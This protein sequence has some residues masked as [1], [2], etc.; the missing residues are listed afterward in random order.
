MST[1]I[2]GCIEVRHPCADEDWYEWEPWQRAMDLSPLYSGQDYAAFGCLFGVRDYMGWEPLAADRGLP[3]D[4]STAIREEFEQAQALDA[5]V[6]SPTWVSWEEL[7]QAELDLSPEGVH[8]VLIVREGGTPYIEARYVVRDQWPAE[9]VE[10]HGTPPMGADPL[11]APYGEWASGT[12]K[13]SYQR[14]TR[15]DVLGPGTGWEHVFAVMRALAD[16]FGGDGVR[17]VVYFD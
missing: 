11:G 10:R 4:A 17:L 8:G 3:A 13:F 16:R 9:F 15:R 14:F 1:D 6:N 5:A 7:D 12:T 2:Y